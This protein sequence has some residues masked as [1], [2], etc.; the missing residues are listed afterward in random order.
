MTRFVGAAWLVLVMGCGDDA[1]PSDAEA[2]AAELGADVGTDAAEDG[3]ND[4]PDARSD[5]NDDVPSDA[6]LDDGEDVGGED[7]ARSCLDEGREV[8]ERRPAG[9]ECNFCECNADGSETCTERSCADSALEGCEYGGVMREYG[10]RFPAA[11]DCNECVCAASGLACTRRFERCEDTAEEGAI[12]LETLDDECGIEGFTPNAVLEA[13]PYSEL[14]APFVYERERDDRLYPET[15][16]DSELTLRIVRDQDGYAVCRIPRAGQEAIDMEVFV[17][18]FT[19]DGSFD[20]TFHSY[21]RRNAGGF[22]NVWTFA[23]SV[24]PGGLNGSY[25]AECPGERGYAFNA[26]IDADRSARGDAVKICE[27]DIALQVGGFQIER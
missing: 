20:E 6:E 12:L 13:L 19:A 18:W 25:E 14:D 21:L 22:T 3:P 23:A 10:V 1:A 15:L 27:V 8:G 17:E 26:T 11:D 4:M 2:D 16:L 9:D 7:A 5:M 24:P